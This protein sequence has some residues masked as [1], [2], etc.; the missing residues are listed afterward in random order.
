MPPFLY[1]SLQTAIGYNSDDDIGAKA[2]VLMDKLKAI[3][4][5]LAL[6]IFKDGLKCTSVTSNI[7]Q[8]NQINLQNAL[9]TVE[10]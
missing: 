4:F 10:Q 2:D 6:V 5:V 7:L 3:N 1:N 8:D 9:D